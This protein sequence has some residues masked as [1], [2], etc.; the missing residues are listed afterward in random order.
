MTFVVLHIG[1]IDFGYGSIP[2]V[3]RYLNLMFETSGQT[4]LQVLHKAFGDLPAEKFIFGSNYPAN[5][6]QCSI[7]LFDILDLDEAAREKL[8]SANAKRI[9]YL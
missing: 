2:F 1:G 6:T 5:I 9:L 7:D 3:G 8:F 4:E